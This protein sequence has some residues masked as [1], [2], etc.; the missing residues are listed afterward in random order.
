LCLDN[1]PFFR[2]RGEVE[3][4]VADGSA[5]TRAA[6]GAEDAEG[7]VLEGKI[8]AGVVGGFDPRFHARAPLTRRRGFLAVSAA[9][10][11]TRK[12]I[13]APVSLEPALRRSRSR[14]KLRI[15]CVDVRGRP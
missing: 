11:D 3:D 8:S 9:R 12:A 2:Q 4:A 13:R 10:N 5:D 7:E 14:R 1:T 6:T 15:R